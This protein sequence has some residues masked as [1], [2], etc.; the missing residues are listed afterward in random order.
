MIYLDV[1]DRIPPGEGQ[2]SEGGRDQYEN[3][4][5]A[6]G[7]VQGILYTGHDPYEPADL[8]QATDPEGHGGEYFQTMIDF[9]ASHSRDYPGMPRQGVEYPGD[10]RSAVIYFARMGWGMNVAVTCDSSAFIVPGGRFQHCAVIGRVADEGL[11]L[12]GQGFYGGT[13]AMSWR[14]L[15]SVYAGG[16]WVC[17]GRYPFPLVPGG[18]A[19]VP[20]KPPIALEVQP[21]HVSW[22]PTTGESWATGLFDGSAPGYTTREVYLTLTVDR[23]FGSP[24]EATVYWIRDD[25]SYVAVRLDQGTQIVAGESVT[26]R[27]PVT[28]NVSVHVV[29][30]NGGKYY[31]AA[32]EVVRT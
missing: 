29:P 26:M 24:L 4:V 2:G 6:G 30:L 1:M 18:P 31:G 27:S 23:S 19:P 8:R 22:D 17:Y 10:L 11:T 7:A 16:L 21:M 12:W 5:Y 28:G 9:M 14:D 3:C 20:S 15:L 13:L 32:H 25:G